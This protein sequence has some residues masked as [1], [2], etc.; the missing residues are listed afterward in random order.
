MSQDNEFYYVHWGQTKYWKWIPYNPS[1]NVLILYT[2]ALSRAY[3]AFATT[4]EAM[5][6]PFF[7]Q[8]RVLQFPGRGR[9]VDKPKLAP[10]EFVAEENGNYWKDVS[11]SEGANAHNRMVETA[12]LL[13]PQQEKPLKVTQQGLLTFNPSPLTNEAKD[14]QLSATNKQAELMQWHHHLGHLPFPKLKPCS[15]WQDP[16]EACHGAASQVCRLPIWRND[17]ASL[18]RQGNQGQPRGL[19]LD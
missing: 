2:T 11:A 13:S 7:Q 6:V 16:E 4:F 5:E 9:S 19:C 1:T 12:N 18:A 8:E 17:E 3:H 14:I 15:Q 10:E